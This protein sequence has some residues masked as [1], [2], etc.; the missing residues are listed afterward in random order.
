[1]GLEG[2]LIEGESG[3][4]DTEERE[5]RED[6]MQDNMKEISPERK[7]RYQT[8]TDRKENNPAAGQTD[9]DTTHLTS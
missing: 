1:M 7:T 5:D 8:M 6:Q 3:G 4:L 2:K 9:E